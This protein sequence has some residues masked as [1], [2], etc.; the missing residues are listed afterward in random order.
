[1]LKCSLGRRVL[2][3][4]VVAELELLFGSKLV[5]VVLML[6]EVGDNIVAFEIV[7]ANNIVDAAT[8]NVEV[9]GNIAA[10]AVGMFEAADN[11]LAFLIEVVDNLLAFDFHSTVIV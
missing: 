6:E 1:M 9:M 4:K 5:Y 11:I 3:C 7:P 10:V 2:D 8:G